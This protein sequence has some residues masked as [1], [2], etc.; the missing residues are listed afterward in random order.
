MFITLETLLKKACLF[1][2]L[3]GGSDG[4]VRLRF[5]SFSGSD[6]NQTRVAGGTAAA[7]RPCS[8]AEDTIVRLSV[9]LEQCV[10]RLLLA[11]TFS[12]VLPSSLTDGIAESDTTQ[13]LNNSD[14]DVKNL[15]SL[16]NDSFAIFYPFKAEMFYPMQLPKKRWM[17]TDETKC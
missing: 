8:G 13:R 9:R 4:G 16:T 5:S 12:R 11:L 3:P 7:P 15:V 10:E 1:K 14:V 6:E 17:L 2:R